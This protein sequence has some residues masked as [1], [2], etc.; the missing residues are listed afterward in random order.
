LTILLCAW[1]LSRHSI[2]QARLLLGLETRAMQQLRAM[3][4]G[5]IQDLAHAP[6]LVLC[7]FHDRPWLWS[8]LLV[9]KRPEG[10]QHLALIA[11]QPGLDK[12]WPVRRA[13]Q[14]SL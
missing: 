1:T 7:A 14:L 12:D 5:P 3:Q 8:E 6:H 2:Y 13:P 4:L 11:L 10:R 9:E